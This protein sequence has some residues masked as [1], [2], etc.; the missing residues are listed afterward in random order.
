MN[1]HKITHIKIQT[2]KKRYIL[3]QEKH[4]IKQSIIK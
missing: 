3:V 1:K 4:H 2:D